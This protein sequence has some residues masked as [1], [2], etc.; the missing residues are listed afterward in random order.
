MD[1]PTK[2]QEQLIAQGEPFFK[3]IIFDARQRS[4]NQLS[5]TLECRKV[6][7]KN[8]LSYRA[9]PKIE[10]ISFE[11][12]MI[13]SEHNGLHGKR[14]QWFNLIA[15]PVKSKST[16]LQKRAKTGTERYWRKQSLT[17]P[18]MRSCVGDNNCRQTFWKCPPC[19]D[20]RRA[21]KL[22][23]LPVWSVSSALFTASPSGRF[24]D[25]LLFALFLRSD[26]SFPML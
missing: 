3:R 14:W 12:C 13:Y 7:T 11:K 20:N 16:K 8:S 24:L 5:V 15:Q 10:N 1:K 18:A 17:P 4:T 21:N 2:Q 6:L 19:H 25:A 23:D 26:N 9:I 22:N